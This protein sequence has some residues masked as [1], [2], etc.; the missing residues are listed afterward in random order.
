ME[1]V[2]AHGPLAPQQ[3][4]GKWASALTEKWESL[5]EEDKAKYAV[6]AEQWR[7]QGPPP[8]VKRRLVFQAEVWLAILLTNN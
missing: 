8:E 5:P 4:I 6:L 7:E 3:Q 2:K 1:A